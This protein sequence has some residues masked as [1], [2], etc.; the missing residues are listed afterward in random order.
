M[1]KLRKITTWNCYATQ[2]HSEFAYKQRRRSQRKFY[3]LRD[4]LDDLTS[5]DRS[6]GSWLCSGRLEVEGSHVLRLSHSYS[7]IIATLIPSRHR[8]MKANSFVVDKRHQITPPRIASYRQFCFARQSRLK[9][10]SFTLCLLIRFSKTVSA[11]AIRAGV[12]ATKARFSFPNQHEII[13]SL[14]IFFTIAA[15]TFRV[16]IPQSRPMQHTNAADFINIL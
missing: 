11:H 8:A 6:S 7:S 3:E 2:R 10:F 15:H 12:R 9:R 1:W 16:N 13:K 4:G 14:K 5:I